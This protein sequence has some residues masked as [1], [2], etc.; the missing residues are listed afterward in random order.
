MVNNALKLYHCHS[1][2]LITDCVWLEFKFFFSCFTCNWDCAGL[3]SNSSRMECDH[4]VL[5]AVIPLKERQITW[6]NE[7]C[8]WFLL[9]SLFHFAF[10]SLTVLYFSFNFTL[11]L[12]GKFFLLE[13][14]IELVWLHVKHVKFLGTYSHNLILL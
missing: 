9:Y 10:I 11:C 3:V 8:N 5:F 13:I 7:Q 14:K 12:Y 1:Q 2:S 6:L 4:A